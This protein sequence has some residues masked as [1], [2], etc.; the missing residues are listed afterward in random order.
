M[1]AT[2]EV[3]AQ[4]RENV[5]LLPVEAV[6]EKENGKIVKVKSPD[7][8]P[9]TRKVETG[10]NNGREVEI[11]SGISENDIVLIGVANNNGNNKRQKAA[12]GIPGMPLGGGRRPH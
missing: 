9:E 10:I 3:E 5:I 11:I 1:T 7:G 6:T 2:I 12:G 8:K 4:K